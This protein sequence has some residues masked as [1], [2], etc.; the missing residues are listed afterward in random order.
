M[1]RSFGAEVTLVEALPRLVPAE[2]EESS[3]ALAR[4]LRKRG[5]TVRTGLGVHGVE[6]SGDGVRL[7]LADGTAIDADL[8]LAA[9]GRVPRTDGLGLDVA[10]VE[11]DGAA[12]KVDERCR[13][14]VP[15]IFAV[16]DATPGPQLAHRGFQQGIFVAE[17][18]A[19]LSPEA[20]ALELVP[21]VT[22]SEPE[23]ASVGI[24][25]ATARLRHGDDGVESLTYDLAGNGRSQILGAQGFV[26]VV[27]RK[28]GPVVGV[29]VVGS[30]AGE[31]DRG[32]AARG[33]LG[34]APRGRGAVRPRPPDP[35]RGPR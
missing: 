26:K 20:V 24:T 7:T 35:G 25:E 8:V 34:G 1:W 4:Q 3:A 14:S 31:L 13:T 21:R 27:R 12:I 10:G 16:G 15:G 29:H 19:G 17:E 23:V 22:Y 9:V 11:L 32:G 2:E 5:I 6:R 18:I 30:R 28:D 33:R